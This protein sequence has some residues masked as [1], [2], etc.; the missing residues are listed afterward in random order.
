MSANHVA[1][2]IRILTT[3]RTVN[4]KRIFALVFGL[5]VS[6]GLSAVQPQAIGVP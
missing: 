6:F 4:S 1:V 2:A 5:L 3:N